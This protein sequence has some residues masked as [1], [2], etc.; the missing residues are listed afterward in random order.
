MPR[1]LK[2]M[3]KKTEEIALGMRRLILGRFVGELRRI[4][5]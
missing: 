4:R 5:K 2:E 3:K 1:K